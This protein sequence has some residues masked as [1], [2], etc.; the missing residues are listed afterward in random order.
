MRPI[1]EN[2]VPW[3]IREVHTPPRDEY[4][5]R[6][7]LLGPD[8]GESHI[9]ASDRDFV[10]RNHVESATH[11]AAAATRQVAEIERELRSLERRLSWTTQT[12]LRPSPRSQ[13]SWFSLLLAFL[14]F[15]AG[16]LGMVVSNLVL[17]EYVL[18][19]ASDLF[20]NNR[21]G[22]VLFATLPCLGAVALKVF[23]LRLISTNARWFY[24]TAVFAVGGASLAVWL[25]SAALVFAPETGASVA[26]LTQ[27]PSD[28]WIGVV[29]VLST[30]I[31]DVTLGATLLSGVGHLLSVKSNSEAVMNPH[32]TALLRRKRHLEESLRRHH[33]QRAAA[34][35]YLSRAAAG[36]EL[37]RLQAEHELERARELW[38]QV[39]SAALAFAIAVF[40]SVEEDDSCDTHLS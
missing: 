31:S 17:S 3:D 30:I 36:R 7:A 37:T 13:R 2:I 9:I 12:V 19:S 21:E 26:L 23:E 22:A 20:A 39:Q 8:G 5:A 32:Y 34:E 29:L 15:C 33:R 18:R 6:A 24:G 1:P 40:L 27:G 10:L 14:V 16:A 4:G 38:T 28:R 35:D 11:A 25:V